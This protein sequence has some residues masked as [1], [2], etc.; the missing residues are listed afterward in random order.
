MT[1]RQP[2]EATGQSWCGP[3]QAA[4]AGLPQVPQTLG[5]QGGWVRPRQVGREAGTLRSRCTMPKLCR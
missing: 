4:G 3:L 5:A 2:E 1:R